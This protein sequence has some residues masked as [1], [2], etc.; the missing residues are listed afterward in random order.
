VPKEFLIVIRRKHSFG[1]GIV[2]ELYANREFVCYTLEL[3]WFWNEKNKSCAPHGKYPGIMRHDY[4]DKWRVELLGVPSNR[5]H[6][7]IHIGNYPRD[8]KGCVLVGSSFAPDAVLT[9]HEHAR[10]S[11][12]PIKDASGLIAVRFEGTH[13]TPWGDYSGTL[14]NTA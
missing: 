9:R 1:Q 4:N 2:G 11:K 8:I 6:V 3:A 5:Q 10:S 14:S 13:S 7:Q 12:L